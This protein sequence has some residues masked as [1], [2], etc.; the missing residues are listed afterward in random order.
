MV[1]TK[2]VDL[3]GL[4]RFYEKFKEYVMSN[5]LLRKSYDLTDAQALDSDISTTGS[6]TYDSAKGA[7][8]VSGTVTI[9]LDRTS[10]CNVIIDVKEAAA[11][12]SITAYGT[13]YPSTTTIV[14]FNVQDASSIIFDVT[15]DY[16]LSSISIEESSIK[17]PTKVSDLEND[18]GFVDMDVN[19]ETLVFSVR[20]DV[21]DETLSLTV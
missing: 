1:Q 9:T 6:I 10:S 20:A 12:G 14:V 17:I 3:N 15:G 4:S 5:F 13:A 16:W 19:D 21:A 18:K 2:Y 11:G 8:K 7:F